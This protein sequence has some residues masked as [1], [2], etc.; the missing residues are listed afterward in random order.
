MLAQSIALWEIPAENLIIEVTESD[1]LLDEEK[2][3]LVIDN[4]VALGC[5]L[6]LDDFGTGYSSMT[7][8]RSMPIDFVKIDQSFVK[9]IAT[10]SEDKAI[11]LSVIK[12]AH[13]LGKAVVAEG[14]EDLACLDILK[15]MECEK[16]QGYCYA[17]PMNFGE[18]ITWLDVFEKQHPA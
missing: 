13:S 3:A 2:A 17:K 15:Q 7:R 14:V 11:V 4:I 5:K 6:A 10:S 16:I 1:L 18:F 12:L 9:N 8:L